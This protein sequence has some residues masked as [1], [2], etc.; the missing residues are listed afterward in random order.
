MAEDSLE[1]LWEATQST[2]MTDVVVLATTQTTFMRMDLDLFLAI[3]T[4]VEVGNALDII[5]LSF[6]KVSL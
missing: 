5:D 6:A 2:F 1:P 4:T 3:H